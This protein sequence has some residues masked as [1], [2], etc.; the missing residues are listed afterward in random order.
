GAL[1][2]PGTR[3]DPD[4]ET[5]TSVSLHPSGPALTPVALWTQPRRTTKIGAMAGRLQPFPAGRLGEPGKSVN[6]ALRSVRQAA[7]LSLDVLAARTNF[8]KPY[9]SNVEAG[10]RRVTPEIAEAYDTA[11]GTGGLLARML[12]G[13]PGAAIGREAELTVLRRMTGELAAGQ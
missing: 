12:A 13:E 3:S 7:G 1:A 10:R 4:G 5:N 6:A 2:V 9:L 11:I 8:S